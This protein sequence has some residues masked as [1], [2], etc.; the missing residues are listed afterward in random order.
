MKVNIVR[1]R[2]VRITQFPQI[3]KEARTYTLM[4]TDFLLYNLLVTCVL[5]SLRGFHDAV[6]QLMTLWAST[7][8]GST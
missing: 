3:H 4:S 5:F 6:N 2:S 7:A 1:L 8:S